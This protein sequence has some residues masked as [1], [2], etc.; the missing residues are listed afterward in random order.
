MIFAEL[1]R[2]AISTADIIPYPNLPTLHSAS[3]RRTSMSLLCGGIR[4]LFF[5][6]LNA[7]LTELDFIDYGNSLVLRGR[8]VIRRTRYIGVPLYRVVPYVR[9]LLI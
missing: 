7:S 6:N 5:L 4:C 1:A 3:E 9:A 8:E 2:Q